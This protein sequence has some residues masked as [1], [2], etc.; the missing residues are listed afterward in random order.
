MPVSASYSDYIKDLLSPFGQIAIRK[1][2]GGGGVY[3]DDLF[4][5]IIGDDDLWLKVDDVTRAQFEAQGLEPFVFEMKDGRTGT[6]SYYGAPEEIYDDHD[7]LK[8]WV[9]LALDAASRAA[10]AKPKK[11]KP[12][13]KPA[14]KKPAK[15]SKSH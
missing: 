6:M 10:K 12:A 9:T 1:M 11:K 7:A 3:C 14:K 5:A 4:F 13:K 15:K 8:E 2:F